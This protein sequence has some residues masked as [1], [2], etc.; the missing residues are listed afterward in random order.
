MMLPFLTRMV[1]GPTKPPVVPGSQSFTTPGTYTFT[2]PAYNTLTVDV[3]GGGGGSGGM[4]HYG[5]TPG[6]GSPGGQSSFRGAIIA[7]GGGPGSTDASYGYPGAHGTATGGDT[8][9]TGGGAAG[10]PTGGGI[11]QGSYN[12]GNGGRAIKSY[13]A[14]ALLY[15]STIT[16]VVGAGGAAWS[17]L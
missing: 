11:M 1:G 12:G 8:N 7:N 4:N 6:A 14:E 2:V 3:R 16:V 5:W 17:Y 15:L 10:G 9:T 13:A